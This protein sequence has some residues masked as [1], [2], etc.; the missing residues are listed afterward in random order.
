MAAIARK[1][2]EEQQGPLAKL[3]QG[4]GGARAAGRV[5]P[6]RTP[7]ANAIVAGVWVFGSV[8]EVAWDSFGRV[9]IWEWGENEP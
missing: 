5:R 1:L 9:T 6:S 2:T 8:V 3:K 4:R 7:V